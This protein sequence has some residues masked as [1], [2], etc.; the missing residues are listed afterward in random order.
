MLVEAV[1]GRFLWLPVV[2]RLCI[3]SAMQIGSNYF[4]EV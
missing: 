4:Q 3:R 1:R 2:S